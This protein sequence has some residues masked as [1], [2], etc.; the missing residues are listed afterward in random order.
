MQV[1]YAEGDR[2]D[3]RLP[4][5]GRKNRS[6]NGYNSLS[7]LSVNQLAQQIVMVSTIC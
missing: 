3:V 4:N 5:C 7:S 6:S 2:E 1:S